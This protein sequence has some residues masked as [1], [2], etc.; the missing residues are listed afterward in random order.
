MRFLDVPPQR[1]FGTNVGTKMSNIPLHFLIF[2]SQAQVYNGIEVAGALFGV[3]F[4]SL[5]CT[6]PND[7]DYSVR[8]VDSAVFLLMFD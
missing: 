1:P 2:F 5:V 4:D 8:T 7:D 3:P 6:R